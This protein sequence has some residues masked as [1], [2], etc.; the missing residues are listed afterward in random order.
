MPDLQALNTESWDHRLD[1]RAH[2]YQL[3]GRFKFAHD[4]LLKHQPK[5]WLDIG[6]GNG[7]LPRVARASLG[8]VRITGTDFVQNALD[9]AHDALDTAVLA[10]LDAKGLPCEDNS[11]DFVT[12][13]E[14]IEHLIFPEHALSEIARVLKPGGRV[15]I[16][17]PNI[18][19]VEYLFQLLRGKMPG[20]A[21]DARHMSIFTHRYLDKLFRQ[22]GMR[23]TVRAGVD[24]SP[25]WFSKISPCYLCKTIAVEGE[26]K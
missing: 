26:K 22:A 6:T 23:M 16:T 15:V 2:T 14:V 4:R 12:C 8:D 19:H 10:D 24:A 7:F 1:S 13:L 11:F 21:A 17:V 20:P 3:R 18:Q 9:A 25:E 5:H